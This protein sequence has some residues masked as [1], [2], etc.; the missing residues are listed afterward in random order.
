LRAEHRSICEEQGWP[1]P[2]GKPAT[3]AAATPKGKKR[4]AVDDEN[5]E[6]PTKPAKKPRVKKSAAKVNEAVE[7]GEDG[8]DAGPTK[9]V[10][11]G[12]GVKEEVIDEI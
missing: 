1:T 12:G 2:D 3:D 6:T 4:G 10:G 9:E 7:E 11:S 5:G 8:N